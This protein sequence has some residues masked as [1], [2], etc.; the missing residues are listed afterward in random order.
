MRGGDP[1]AGAH[2]LADI[3]KTSFRLRYTL[4]GVP[5]ATVVEPAAAVLTGP[6]SADE[7]LEQ[8]RQMLRAL[9]AGAAGACGVVVGVAGYLA[10][11]A[12]LPDLP[13]RVR[14]LFSR[15]RIVLT[16]DLALAHAGALGGGAGAVLVAGTGAVALGVASTGATRVADGLGPGAGDRGGGAW[17]G[18]EALIDALQAGA[19]GSR[20][21]EMAG[22]LL[23]LERNGLSALVDAAPREA[24]RLAQLAPLMLDALDAGDE[25]AA[26]IV[27]R[28]IEHLTT[29]LAEAAAALTGAERCAAVVGG[30]SAHALFRARLS[31]RVA[32]IAEIEVVAAEGD[33]L[34]GAGILARCD[35]VPALPALMTLATVD[36]A[37]ER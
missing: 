20:F 2:V 21:V 16:S 8:L 28:A 22:A 6:A 36:A 35:A 23:G 24:R 11:S 33:A 29:T 12:A 9:P 7:L 10:H 13:A 32:A 30:L 31:A 26:G 1:R 25:A 14:A 5:A 15:A 4:D 19:Y 18:R 27:D 3:G 37:P 17:I 34:A